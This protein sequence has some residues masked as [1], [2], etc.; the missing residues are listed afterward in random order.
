MNTYTDAE[1]GRVLKR[2]VCARCYNDLVK[3]SAPGRTWEAYC[4]TCGE[5]WGGRHIS[6]WTAERR[7]Q[8]ALAEALEVRVTLADLFPSKHKGK[9]AEQ[10]MNEL[11][12]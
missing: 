1:I 5:A 10:L 11:G 9:S 2:R 7:G 8:R 6:R 4:P 3:R 12:M